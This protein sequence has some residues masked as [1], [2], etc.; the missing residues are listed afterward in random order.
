M[1]KRK[2]ESISTE[3]PSIHTPKCEIAP[4]IV[5]VN[6]PD[7]D[8]EVEVAIARS[9]TC[10]V[11]ESREVTPGGAETVGA[12]KAPLTGLH[13]AFA[14]STLHVHTRGVP[15]ST[16]VVTEA[17]VTTGQ[18]ETLEALEAFWALLLEAG[19]KPC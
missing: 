12:N 9:D 18:R 19:Y 4:S 5:P 13:V 2:A 14:N 3:E 6:R 17:E 15:A 8:S 10:R 1:A 7:E 16:V 11:P